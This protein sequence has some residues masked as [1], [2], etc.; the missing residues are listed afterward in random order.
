MKDEEDGFG[1]GEDVWRGVLDE[2]R[3]L[4]RSVAQQGGSSSAAGTSMRGGG[5]VFLRQ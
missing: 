5:T 3:E 1:S 2:A 4:F